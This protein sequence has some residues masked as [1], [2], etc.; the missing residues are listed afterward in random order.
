MR[1]W[2]VFAVSGILAVTALSAVGCGGSDTGSGSLSDASSSYEDSSSSSES[3]S[4]SSSSSESASDSSSSSKSDSSSSSS[5]KSSSGSNAASV[6][7]A[8]N[9]D[10]LG[11]GEYYCMGKNDTCKNK[12]SSPT[13][14][15]CYS[16][17]PDGNNIEGDQRKS[18]THDG[19]V[20]DNDYDGDV[21]DEDF[22]DEWEDFLN[23]K[24]DENDG[25]YYG[26]YDDYDYG[27]GGYDDYDYGY[28]W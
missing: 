17:D 27:Y 15:Y 20:G 21:D 18:N 11:A 25:G 4:D 13:D 5:S 16:C 2:T 3:A 12:T 9:D 6:G 26:G 23:D 8:A 14:L 10:D 22:E 1:K 28:G 24:M 19:V 7:K